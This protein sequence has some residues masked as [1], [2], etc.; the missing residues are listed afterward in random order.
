MV[1]HSGVAFTIWLSQL[2]GIFYL[3]YSIGNCIVHN[4]LTRHF[5][6]LKMIEK[7]FMIHTKSREFEIKKPADIDPK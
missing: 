3:I 5:K 1:K 6:L 4:K 2:G 7:H